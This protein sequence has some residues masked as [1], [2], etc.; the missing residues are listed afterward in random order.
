MLDPIVS[1]MDGLGVSPMGITVTGIL[2][3]VVGAVYVARGRF[4]AG[5]V[6]LLVSGLCDTIDGSLARKQGKV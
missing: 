4:F 1:L 3:S 5:A 6:L 2:I